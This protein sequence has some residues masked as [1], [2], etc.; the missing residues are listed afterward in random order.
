MAFAAQLAEATRALHAPRTADEQR[1]ANAWLASLADDASAPA[2][3]EGVLRAP[4]DLPE[5]ALVVAAG[6]VGAAT[7]RAANSAALPDL[8]QLFGAATHRPVASQL[9]AAAAATAASTR[10]EPALVELTASLDAPRQLLVLEALADAVAAV[11]SPEEAAARP[12]A[13]EA[14]RRAVA[15]LEAA[16]APS[17][18]AD[19]AAALRCVGAWAACGVCTY[20]ALAEARP[21]VCDALRAPLVDA[22]TTADGGGVER[23]ASAAAVLHELVRAGVDN[24]EELEAEAAAP[25]LQALGGLAALV[26]RLGAPAV[27]AA[28]GLTDGGAAAFGEAG[29]A[30]A[31][32]LARLG[33]IFVEALAEAAA[34][35]LDG[36][37]GGG[38]LEGLFALL[39]ACT[40]HP[41]AAVADAAADGWRC[42]CAALPPP[43]GG[44]DPPWRA[45]VCEQAAT[46][47]L[48]RCSAAQLRRGTGDDADDL[49]FFREACAAPALGALSE[50]LGALR[51]MRLVDAALRPPLQA[52]TSGAADGAAA[53]A[54]EATL[55]G[56]ACTS[57]R[58]GARGANGEGAEELALQLIAHAEAVAGGGAGEAAQTQALAALCA[59]AA[60]LREQPLAADEGSDE[61]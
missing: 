4:G 1:A 45:A 28:S 30:L 2:L 56:A 16:L 35:A 15:L 7:R 52:L 14:A 10:S 11:A 32:A 23:A 43:P 36:G 3:C 27:D 34:A 60:A 5:A 18:D 51:W 8:L 19:A 21:G 41:L 29:A 42:F 48:A 59:L 22:A 25:L 40:D 37:G 57:P 31:V 55:F 6:V 39:L 47:L 9:A 54:V 58:C 46:R 24:F 12:G 13:A 53:E 17:A 50:E 44:V 26:G 33:A 49:A 61:G 38:E 20:G